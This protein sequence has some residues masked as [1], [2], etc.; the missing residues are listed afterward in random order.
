MGLEGGIHTLAL[1]CMSQGT[2]TA[3]TALPWHMQT[4]PRMLGQQLTACQSPQSAAQAWLGLDA[5]LQ[6]ACTPYS[7]LCDRTLS[8][9][10]PGEAGVDS[11]CT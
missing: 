8:T 10:R 5:L 7:S 4:W 9:L 11:H 2:G 6:T 1:K 3:S